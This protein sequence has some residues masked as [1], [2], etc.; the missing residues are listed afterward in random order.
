VFGKSVIAVDTHV[1]RVC[2]RI[3]LTD[4]GAADKTAQQLERIAPRGTLRDGHFWLIQFGKRVCR[5]RA[6][7]CIACPVN[8]LCRYYAKTK[9]AE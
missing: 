9:E 6:P 5:S 7:D 4:A 2:N 3:G 1:H 8:D